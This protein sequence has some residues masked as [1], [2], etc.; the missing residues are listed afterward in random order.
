MLKI[1]CNDEAYRAATPHVEI[2]NNFLNFLAAKL[3]FPNLAQG[4][5]NFGF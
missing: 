1:D 5:Q 3:F 4:F 2:S